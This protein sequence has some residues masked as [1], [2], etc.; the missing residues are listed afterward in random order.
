MLAA[1]SEE[2]GGLYAHPGI[3]KVRGSILGPYIN[4]LEAI[5]SNIMVS[6]SAEDSL[7]KL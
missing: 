7:L 4:I 6:L 1:V 5:S 3:P 2:F